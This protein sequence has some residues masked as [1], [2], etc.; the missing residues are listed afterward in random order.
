[1]ILNE[2]NKNM[3]KRDIM[4]TSRGERLQSVYSLRV[5]SELD[6][7]CTCCSDLPIVNQPIMIYPYIPVNYNFQAPQNWDPTTMPV[8]NLEQAIYG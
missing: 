8:V 5:E 2:S 1:M 3:D 6:A 7:P 4:P